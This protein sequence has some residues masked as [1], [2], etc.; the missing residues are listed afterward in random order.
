MWSSIKNIIIPR[1]FQEALKAKIDA[2][3]SFFAGGSYLVSQKNET[4]NTLID[5]NRIVSH[6]TT[7]S[8]NNIEIG[9]GVTIESLVQSF[10][11]TDKCHLH[12]AALASCPSKNI[13]NQRTLGGEIAQGDHFSDL[14]IYLNTL[15]PLL[16][17]Y[18]PGKDEIRMDKWSKIGIIDS[19]RIETGNIAKSYYQRYALIPSAPAFLIIAAVR[20][21]NLV[22]LSIGGK[23]FRLVNSEC[24]FSD[25]KNQIPQKILKEVKRNVIVDQY[26]SSEYKLAVL[27]TGLKR[28]AENL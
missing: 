27:K 17:I 18:N 28:M 23:S 21:N 16:R 1:D 2:K 25:L 4:V 9:A 26:G 19:I 13:R 7:D 24:S 8:E 11:I 20:R 5:I 10:T 12:N 6:N 14:Y 22:T 3:A 15:H